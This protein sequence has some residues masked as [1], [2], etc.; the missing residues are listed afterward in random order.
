MILAEPIEITR[1]IVKA[2]ESLDIR[3]LVGGSLASSLYGIPRAT[4]DVDIIAE[5]ANENIQELVKALE[6]DF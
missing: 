3:Y 1:Q 6:S 5:I 2:L 4:H